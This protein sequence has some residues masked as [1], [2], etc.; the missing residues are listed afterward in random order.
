MSS[1]L[2]RFAH[3]SREPDPKTARELARE[4]WHRDGTICLRREWF[5]GPIGQWWV[6]EAMAVMI[7]GKRRPKSVK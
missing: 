6:V 1:T 2:A 3:L 4:A 5:N 7:F